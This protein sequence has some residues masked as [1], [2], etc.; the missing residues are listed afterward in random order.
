[1]KIFAQLLAICVTIGIIGSLADRPDKT[2]F[3]LVCGSVLAGIGFWIFMRRIDDSVWKNRPKR[4]CTNCL[5]LAQPFQKKNGVFY[6]PYC[7]A[8]NPAPLDSP[9]ARD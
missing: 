6:W 2:P 3:L 9:F 7:Q 5:A 8:D 4:L 1:M